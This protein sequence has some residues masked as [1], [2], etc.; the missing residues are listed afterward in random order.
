MDVS[1]IFRHG[2]ISSSPFP[3]ASVCD[4]QGAEDASFCCVIRGLTL[5]RTGEL[6]RSWAEQCA[7]ID[8]LQ[9]WGWASTLNAGAFFGECCGTRFLHAQGM[10]GP[11]PASTSLYSPGPSSSQGASNRYFA[12][13]PNDGN[14]NNMPG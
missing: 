6:E 1:M 3:S 11:P 13:Y 5:P 14:V 8:R 12:G 4:V 2:S 9:S 10:A 7:L